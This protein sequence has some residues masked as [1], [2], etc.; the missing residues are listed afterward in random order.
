MTTWVY[1]TCTATWRPHELEPQIEGERLDVTTPVVA[2]AD[3]RRPARGND[4]AE[5]LAFYERH[6]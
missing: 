3:A 1:D 2:V 6:P 4:H 5:G